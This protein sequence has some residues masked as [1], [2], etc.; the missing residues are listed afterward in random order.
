MGASIDDDG[1]EPQSSLRMHA[2][3]SR[4]SG[5]LQASNRS[6]S[7]HHSNRIV[8]VHTIDRGAG[9]EWMAAGRQSRERR[10]PLG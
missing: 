10:S 1:L 7:I 9:V 8:S 4:G 2:H 6:I 5:F 3:P